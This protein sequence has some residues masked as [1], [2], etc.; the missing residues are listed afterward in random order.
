MARNLARGRWLVNSFEADVPGS[1]SFLRPVELSQGLISAHCL[2]SRSLRARKEI[3]IKVLVPG[4]QQ[5]GGSPGRPPITCL[6]MECARRGGAKKGAGTS[7]GKKRGRDICWKKRGAV[8]LLEKRSGTMHCSGIM[9]WWGGPL[10]SLII[11]RRLDSI[12]IF[13]PKRASL[14]LSC[15]CLLHVVAF[16]ER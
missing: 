2:D 6:G 5:M 3:T 1:L 9:E 13:D 16:I 10:Q 15:T 11:G 8:Y 14:Y 4:N 7:A 12:K